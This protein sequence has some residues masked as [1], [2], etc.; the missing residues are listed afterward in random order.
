MTDLLRRSLAPLTQQAWD[1]I[2][3][4]AARV[5]KSQLTARGIVDFD[6]PRGWDHAA[7]NLGRLET[8]S[9]P[10]PNEVPWGKRLVLPLIEARVPFQLDQMELDNISR[11]VKD[12]DLTPLEDAARRIA[13]FEES[14]VYNGFE[15]AGIVGILPQS[16]HHP[17]NLPPN[18]REFPGTVAR[19]VEAMRQIGIAG[20]FVLVLGAEAWTGLMQSGS[21]GYPPQRIIRNMIGDDPRMSPAIEGGVLL[22]SADGY[23]EL[24]VG[25]DFSIG[26]ANHDRDR[27]ELYLT[28]TFTFRV[29]EPKACVRLQPT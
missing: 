28:E 21:G 26:Y 10:A 3:E 13:L 16:A 7:V 27:L 11:G 19:A 15:P 6:G 1:E 17:I 29:L 9:K 12:A 5:I 24:S 18:T 25:Q 20:P 8:A 4:T 22:S 14:A 23:F 2:D